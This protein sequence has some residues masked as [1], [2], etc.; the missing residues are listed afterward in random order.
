MS[1][2]YEKAV[3]IDKAKKYCLSPV[4]FARDTEK[5]HMGHIPD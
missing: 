1:G 2:D 4:F 5:I 3:S